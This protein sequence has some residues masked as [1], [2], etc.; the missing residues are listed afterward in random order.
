VVVT[1]PSGNTKHSG[2]FMAGKRFVEVAFLGLATA[3]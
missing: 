1:L 3:R 2:S